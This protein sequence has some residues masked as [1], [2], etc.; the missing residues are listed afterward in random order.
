MRM[1]KLLLISAAAT[2]A[3]GVMW[4]GYRFEEPPTD[5]EIGRTAHSNSPSENR[6]APSLEEQ[7]VRDTV[8]RE[9]V[10][11]VVASDDQPLLRLV[12]GRVIDESG[13]AVEGA[14]V[15]LM[16]GSGRD[17]SRP[18]LTTRTCTSDATGA[19]Q[20]GVT[21]DLDSPRLV[22]SND[23]FLP[24]DSLSLRDIGEPVQ[25]VLERACALVGRLVVDP[26][27]G[28]GEIRLVLSRAGNSDIER[29]GAA[30][31]SSDRSRMYSVGDDGSFAIERIPAHH[32]GRFSVLLQE[33]FVPEFAVDDI[34]VPEEGA[35]PDPRL[36]PLDLSGRIQ[37][38]RIEVQDDTG[39]A[40]NQ[41][42][43]V[44]TDPTQRMEP[45]EHITRNGDT[46]FLVPNGAYDLDVDLPGWESVHL[47]GVT[48]DQVIRLHSLGNHGERPEGYTVTI[49]LDSRTSLP[50]QPYRLAVGLLLEPKPL[51]PIVDGSGAFDAARRVSFIASSLGAHEVAWYLEQGGRR[52]YL[53]GA[54]RQSVDV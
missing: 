49:V 34:Q 4:L 47:T 28:F 13:A 45:R 23:G 44:L 29:G 51:R 6:V 48:G 9:E 41:A 50:P 5:R 10:P 35:P 52:H 53:E 15:W 11:A 43:V 2:A 8:S 36:D 22:A 54:P 39:R 31:L 38:L 46:V 27:I 30:Y 1:K 19:F 12:H 18:L 16:S 26:A 14:D 7:A 25:V 24:S 3:V 42:H 33:Q 21:D 37:S 17:S 32:A 40:R 20:F